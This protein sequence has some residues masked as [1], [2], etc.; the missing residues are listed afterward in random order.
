MGASDVS[1]LE[2]HLL[3][4]PR[5]TRDGEAAP[6]PRGHKVWGL[7]AYLLRADRPP[8]RAELVSLLFAEADDPLA[9]L[10][11]NLGALRRLLGDAAP[12]RGSWATSSSCAAATTVPDGGSS[13]PRPCPATTA[14]NAVGSPVISASSSP[15]RPTTSARSRN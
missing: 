15:T 8:S 1:D 13:A 3:G 9:T 7:L 6:N 10:R 2:I 4:Q 14:P 11:W 12:H 5:V